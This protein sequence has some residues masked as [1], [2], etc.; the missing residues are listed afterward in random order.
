[1]GI[2]IFQLPGA[3]ALQTAEKHPERDEAAEA[4]LPAGI[5]LRDRVQP[6]D[7][8][9]RSR[10]TRCSTRCFEA[11]ILV[12]IVVLDLPAIVAGDGHPAVRRAGVAHRHVRGDEGVRLLA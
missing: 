3:N 6:D 2:G 12:V 8:H 10:S 11:I 7:V 5:E 1:M 9:R 4:E